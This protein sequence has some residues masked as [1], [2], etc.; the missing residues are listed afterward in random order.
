[1]TMS[2][3]LTYLNIFDTNQLFFWLQYFFANNLYIWD[4]ENQEAFIS[5]YKLWLYIYTL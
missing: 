4:I 1:M 5:I 2:H 3:L